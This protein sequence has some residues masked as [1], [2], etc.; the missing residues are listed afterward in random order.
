MFKN[1][2]SF[3]NFN[4]NYSLIYNKILE[5]CNKYSGFYNCESKKVMIINMKKNLK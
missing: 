2:F 4:I 3:Y 1:V 5:E